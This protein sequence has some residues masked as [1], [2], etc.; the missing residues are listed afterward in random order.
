MFENL[1]ADL[2]HYKEHTRYPGGLVRL[3][4]RNYFSNPAWAGVVWYRFGAWAWRLRWPGIRHF[5]KLIYLL[6]LP[7]VRLYSGVQIQPKTKIGPGLAILHFGGVIIAEDCEIGPNCT[8]HQQFN[9]VTKNYRQAAR[10]GA[11]FYAGAGVTV[12]GHVI[13]EDNVVCGAGSVVTRSVP[14]NAIVGGVPAKIIRFRRPNEA[15]PKIVV[16]GHGP[17]PWMEI[18]P[19][20]EPSPPPSEP[21]VRPGDEKANTSGE[22]SGGA[23]PQ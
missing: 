20:H 22:L 2:Q 9:L 1:K 12:V 16:G 21:G 8:L 4:F 6:G 7:W 14:A 5:L 23:S 15:P 3:F 10:I 18:P 13:I 11:N 19:G 17:V